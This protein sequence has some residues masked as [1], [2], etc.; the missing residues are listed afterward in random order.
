MT[1]SQKREGQKGPLSPCLGEVKMGE[2][3]ANHLV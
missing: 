3:E 1:V 2:E